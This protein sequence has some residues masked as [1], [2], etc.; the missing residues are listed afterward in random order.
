MRLIFVLLVSALYVA[1]CKD[2]TPQAKVSTPSTGPASATEEELPLCT[3]E[4]IESCEVEKENPT[5]TIYT[6]PH[7]GEHSQ[8]TCRCR[9]E[10]TGGK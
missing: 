7:C 4:K 9:L 10:K 5:Q 1:G 2:S 6:C 8:A 3:V